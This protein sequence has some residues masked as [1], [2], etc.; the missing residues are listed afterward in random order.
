VR[1]L[2][3]ASIKAVQIQTEYRIKID[4][5]IPVCVVRRVQHS[6]ST[7]ANHAIKRM[8]DADN[9]GTGRVIYQDYIQFLNKYAIPFFGKLVIN[10]I[11]E[12][13]ML[14]FDVWRSG[15]MGR[16]PAQSTV[17]NHNSTLQIA[18]DEAMSRKIIIAAETPTLK[19]NGRP[20]ERRA[21]FTVPEYLKRKEEARLWCGTGR[22]QITKDTRTLLYYYLQFAVMTGL[23]PGKEIEHLTWNDVRTDQAGGHLCTFVT[24][25]KGKTTKFTGVREIVCKK[26]V[27]DV[28]KGMKKTLL[29][30]ETDDLIFTLP[31]GKTSTEIGKNFTKL[32]EKIGLKNSPAGDRSL[33]S[34]RQT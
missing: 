4:A 19:K 32:L 28:L 29:S 13:T 14:D 33:Y 6:F 8:Q 2:N 12:Q 25:R 27:D 11:D 22:K 3:S 20:G 16:V 26:G 1:D 5:G 30:A 10:Q 21:A 15:Q 17:Q 24:L 18:S 23:R 7:V 34:L 9:N 31:D